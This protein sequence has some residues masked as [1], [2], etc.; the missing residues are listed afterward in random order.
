MNKNRIHFYR[1]ILSPIQGEIVYWMSRDQRIDFNWAFTYAQELANEHKLPLRI[2]FALSPV[3]LDATFRQYHFMI[4]GLKQVEKRALELGI[5]FTLLL[6][7]VP[8]SLLSFMNSHPIGAVITDFDPLAIKRIWKSKIL[9]ET[10]IPFIEIDAHNIVPCRIVSQKIEFG[11]YTI[12][13]KIKRL[14][15]EYFEIPPEPLN[16]HYNNETIENNTNWDAV[17]SSLKVSMQVLQSEI[18]L[19]GRNEGLKTLD[20]FIEQKIEGYATLRNDPTKGMISNVSPYLH[21]GQLSAIECAVKAKQYETDFPESVGSF[22]EEL[23]VRREL[24][25]NYCFYNLNYTSFDGFPEWAKKSLNEHRNDKREF[26][27]TVDEF[28]ECRTHDALWNAAQ[29]E[30]VITGK[31]HGY[32]RMYWAK[33]ILEWTQTPEEA[34]SIALYLNDRYQLDGRDPNGY[35]GV[36]WSIGGVHDRAWFERPI[37][38]KIRY[39]NYNGCASKFDVKKYIQQQNDMTQF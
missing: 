2:V 10:T 31:M 20:A 22:L 36:A 11:A 30:M 4:E 37:Y 19:P 38:G 28:E 17:Y 26:L 34:H 9:A 33:K 13:P 1:E 24:S 3:F 29:K 21:F 27:Y 23:I 5:P 8:T 12:R 7:D 39:M 16:H 18:Y 6:G 15:D 32:M 14:L 35:V 25:D